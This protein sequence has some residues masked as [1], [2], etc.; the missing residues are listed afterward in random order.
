MPLSYAV[1]LALA[2]A[3]PATPASAH[4]VA[5]AFGARQGIQGI[6]LSPE[7]K[8]VAIIVPNGRGKAL[9]VVD[10]VSGGAPQTILRSAGAG[11]RLERCR[12]ATEKRLL[13]DVTLVSQ[14]GL[15]KRVYFSRLI[16]LNRDGSDVKVM[17]V[18]D[19]A[20]ALGLQQFGGGVID[21][22]GDGQGA[23]LM[24]RDFVPEEATDS[25]I[26]QRQEGLGVERVDATSIQRKMVEPPRRNAA[27]Y[28]TD[29][30]GNIRVMGL[31]VAPASGHVS[32]EYE[33]Q[34]RKAG[35]R[36]WLTLSRY[37]WNARTGF[38]P[39]AVD[40][41]QNVVYGFDTVD[42][43]RVFARISLDGK[44]KKEVLLARPDVDVDDIIQVG[45]QS[46]VVGASYATDKRVPVYS[47]QPLNQLRIALGRALPQSPIISIVDASSDENKLLIRSES[48]TDPGRF[49]LFDKK[50]Q[51]LEEILPVRP[52]MAG[53]KLAPV[54]PITYAAADGT[55]IPAYLTLPAGSTGKNLP[56]IVMPHGGPSAR[57]EWGFDW[58]AQFFAARGYA[59]LQPNYRG[60]SGYGDAWFNKNGWQS[61]RT[62]VGDVND[63]GRYLQ[64]SGIAAP[65]KLAIV[66]WSYGG[67]AALQSA[68]VDPALFK[69]IV[70]IA[71]V[72]DL[73]MLRRE[74]E[75]FDNYQV[76][77]RYIGTGEHIEAGS[78]LRHVRDIKAPVLL[79]HGDQDDNVGVGQSR[80]MEQRMTAA[81]KKVTYVEYKGLDHQLDDGPT[82]TEMLSKSDAFLRA[83]LGL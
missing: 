83:S 64:S 27:E 80:A 39:Y 10:M 21:W 76:M 4:D 75:G 81:G 51:N 14:Q 41:D 19:G 47:D 62:A 38:N 13:C 54:K 9:Q 30:H 12:W 31:Y 52:Q 63:A 8:Q 56:A 22:L 49:Y 65:G 46:R 57:D 26:A 37:D 50:V 15:T 11:D 17:T 72:T 59:V 32:T 5:A 29:G 45:R 35:A 42:G 69:A 48:D 28:I 73:D 71:P 24:T 77:S 78:P 67:Y 33:Y 40:P 2:A 20:R 18:R 7:G 1:A 55:M 60:S 74:S 23:V 36:D 16:S 3:A 66:G 34:Y 44:L 68:V 43:R 61:W 79:F 6:S 53:Q 58:L 82:R 25:R 70:A